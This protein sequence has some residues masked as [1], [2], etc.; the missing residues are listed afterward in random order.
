M[1]A[2]GIDLGSK[3]IGLAISDSLGVLATPYGLIERSGKHRDDHCKIAE[4]VEE[5]G[6]GCVVVGMPIDLRGKVAVAAKNAAAEVAELA[7]VVPVPVNT[8]DERM[9]T[10]LAAKQLKGI[11]NVKKR[12]DAS[13]AAVMLQGWLD[14]QA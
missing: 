14:S 5:E 11:K 4:L 9:T 13:A 10:A 6:V 8:F 7:T 2:L 3:R 12:I 1:R